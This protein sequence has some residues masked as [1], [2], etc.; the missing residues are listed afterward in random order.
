MKSQDAGGGRLSSIDALRG[1]DMFWIIGGDELARHFCQRLKSF[2]D[3]GVFGW[4]AKRIADLEPQF[5]H[6]QWHGF[7]FYDLIFP[8]FLF[9]VGCVLPFSLG[10]YGDGPTSGA[11]GRVVRRTLAL[12]ALGFVYS[13][14]LQLQFLRIEGSTFY[15]DWSQS[16]FPGVLQRIGLCYFFAALVVMNC[17]PTVQMGIAAALLAGYHAL[18][19]FVPGGGPAGDYSPEG[20]LAGWIDRAAFDGTRTYYGGENEFSGLGDNEGVLSTLPAIATTLIG[21]LAG[22]LLRSGVSPFLKTAILFV[23]GAAAVQGG[24]LW[25]QMLGLP[26]NKMLWSSSFVLVAAGWSAILLGGFY[27]VID[28]CG[29]KAWAFFFVVI[30]A[31]AITIYLLQRIVD[32][33]RSAAFLFGGLAKLVGQGDAPLILAAGSL[34]LQW[35]VLWFFYRHRVFLR[36]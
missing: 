19:A 23:S 17:R 1:F 16:R 18:L 34:G 8:L 15:F 21:A 30:G 9:L 31:N 20:N 13:G 14:F 36:V 10:K 12:I 3:D 27:F 35:L 29:L 32:F 2:S 26:V 33:E 24:W 22:A 5:H 11:V 7:R 6:A 28:V 4:L 25:E